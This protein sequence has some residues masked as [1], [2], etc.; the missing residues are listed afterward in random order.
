M[1]MSSTNTQRRSRV[2][3]PRTSAGMTKWRRPS[4]LTALTTPAS[5]RMG[6]DFRMSFSLLGGSDGRWLRRTGIEGGA[7]VGL[8]LRLW[9]SSAIWRAFGSLAWHV[10][11]SDRENERGQL[12]YAEAPDD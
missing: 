8:R 1:P 12:A 5:F 11:A 10:R 9:L 4:P 7:L 2:K 3:R 6:S